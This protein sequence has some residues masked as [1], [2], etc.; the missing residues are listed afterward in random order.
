MGNMLNHFSPEKKLDQQFVQARKRIA[1]ARKKVLN[2]NSEVKN[3]REQITTNKKEKKRTVKKVKFDNWPFENLVLAGGGAKGVAYCGLA[4]ALEERDILKEIKRFAGASAGSIVA[5]LLYIGYNSHDVEQ[6][7]SVN[8]EILLKD[9][10]TELLDIVQNL[11]LNFGIHPADKFKSFIGDVFAHK[12][13]NPD[14]TFQEAY[15]EYQK[16]ELCVVVTNVNTMSIEY[17]HVKTTPNMPIRDAVRM[18]MSIPGEFQPVTYTIFEDTCLHVDG[19]VICN[20]P[21]NCFDGWYLSTDEKLEPSFMYKEPFKDS[22]IDTNW[23]TLGCLVYSENEYH[24]FREQIEKICEVP[25]GDLPN[26]QLAREWKEKQ[27]PIELLTFYKDTL[28]AKDDFLKI[29]PDAKPDFTL[30]EFE[31]IL[32]Q[33]WNRKDNEQEVPKQCAEMLFGKSIDAETIFKAMHK[34]EKNKVTEKELKTFVEEICC[35]VRRKCLHLQRKRQEIPDITT[36]MSTMIMGLNT[37]MMHLFFQEGDVARTVGINTW[38]IE[39]LDF[40]LEP[41]DIQFLL[42]H[43]RSSTEKFLEYFAKDHF[44][45]NPPTTQSVPLPLTIPQDKWDG[46]INK[47]KV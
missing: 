31:D 47:Y 14:I 11:I 19:G 10:P 17:C 27:R 45:N 33:A 44:M 24:P 37:A 34:K 38:Y 41:G 15:D 43:G 6:I 4:R 22:N 32:I 29:I 23:K 26:T 28:K 40:A 12:T 16:K 1:E 7:M 20:Y 8:M 39:A 3:V 9:G 46:I 42:D 35:S 5:S 13:N 36:Y 18:S 2:D 21:I 30:K 25:K